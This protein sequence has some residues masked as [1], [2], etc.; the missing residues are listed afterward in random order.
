MNFDDFVP[1]ARLGKIKKTKGGF[2]A[3]LDGEQFRV[4]VL[5]ADL[6]R[7]K[8]SKNGQFD[9]KPS[10]ALESDPVVGK[11]KF[12]VSSDGGVTTLTTKSVEFRINHEPFSMVMNRRADGS[13]VFESG[14]IAYATDGE[15]FAVTRKIGEADPIY[16]LG[17]KT[18]RFNRRGRDFTLWNTDVLNPTASGEFT[19]QYAKGD[20][21]AD[22]TSTEFDPYYV[23][24]PFYYHQDESNGDMSGSFI[25]NPYRGYYDFTGEHEIK[26]QF[27]GGQYTEYVFAGPEMSTILGQYTSLTGRT[28]LPPLWALG[29]H[30]CRW[31]GYNQDDVERLVAKYKEVDVPLDA[32][33]LDIDYMDGYRVFTWNKEKYPDPEAMLRRLADQGVKVITII[34]PGVKEDPGYEVYD[35]G[36]E[37]QVFAITEKGDTYIGQVWPG[38]TAFPDFA[39]EKAREWWGELNARHV[40]SGLAGIWNDMNEPATGDKDPLPM[41]F[42]RGQFEHEKF[43]N[44]YA[45]L[46]A[47]GTTEGLLK[48]MPNLRTFVLSRAGSA[49]IQ[50]YAANWMG[51][52]MSRWDHLWLSIPM[53]NGFSVSGQSFVG[54]DIG[55]FAEDTNAELYT[56]WIQCGVLTPFARVHSVINT[57]DQYAWSF[58]EEVLGY[59]REAIKLRY[60]LLPYIYSSFVLANR[61][62]APVQGPL[63]FDHQW[64]KNTWDIDDQY[65]FGPNLLVAPIV[66]PGKTSRSVYLPEGEWFD[67][68]TG[69]HYVSQGRHFVIDAPINRIPVF[70]RA[71]AVIPMLPEAPQNTK[72]LA[73]KK[74]QYHVFLPQQDGEYMSFVQE[75]DGITFDALKGKRIETSFQVVRNG[76][77]FFV[78][79]TTSGKKFDGFS[80]EE[81]ELVF[82][83]AKGVKSRTDAAAI[84]GFAIFGEFSESGEIASDVLVRQKG[85]L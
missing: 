70:A 73:P 6:I 74:L 21:R 14:S 77:R 61:Y 13:R 60:R 58:G 39:N 48:A 47:M 69:D 44:Q 76:L 75:D 17:E 22:N 81:T 27:N 26:I 9:E 82:H 34:D 55:G 62:G 24:I 7:I 84:N 45:M 80:R 35:D 46:M 18:G 20:P 65:L 31:F 68:H 41:R 64:D 16:G 54:A 38:D 29:F 85:K 50:R 42:D 51:D 2:I 43:H 37:K 40:K 67:F 3:S 63:I 4:D 8:V 36:L 83:T 1:L 52:N 33:W 5:S 59:A 28:A 53:G 12:K 11:E 10:H 19:G 71:G 78:Q 79:A 23:S 66:E 30:Q 32:F 57:I 15:S 25:D 72:D 49:G 56:R